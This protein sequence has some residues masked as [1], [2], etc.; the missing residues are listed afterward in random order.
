MFWGQGGHPSFWCSLLPCT[1]GFTSLPV[2][3]TGIPTHVGPGP[4]V[5][6]GC[7]L[8]EA[9][10]A[11][12]CFPSSLLLQ[13]APHPR[14]LVHLHHSCPSS[15]L[16]GAGKHPPGAGKLCHVLADVFKPHWVQGNVWTSTMMALASSGPQCPYSR[17]D[18]ICGIR[19]SSPDRRW[20][21]F[22]TPAPWLSPCHMDL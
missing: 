22:S 17:P 20:S 11:F 6:R 8:C 14:Q 18:G 7:P 9:H 1:Y 15:L 21:M 12:Y 4:D 5:T 10:R 3:A 13:E 2:S 19:R 16:Q